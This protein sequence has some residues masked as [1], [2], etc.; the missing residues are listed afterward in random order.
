MSTKLHYKCCYCDDLFH[1]HEE[2]EDQDLEPC[3]DASCNEDEPPKKGRSGGGKKK[4]K[5]VIVRDSYICVYCMKSIYP[6]RQFGRLFGLGLVGKYAPIASRSIFGD[7]KWPEYPPGWN[8]HW[9][10]EILIMGARARKWAE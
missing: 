8:F 5:N 2:E 3:D 9:S 7:P 4:K 10:P 1:S 6:K